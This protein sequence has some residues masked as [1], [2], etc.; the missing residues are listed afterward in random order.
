MMR[1][2]RSAILLALALSAVPAAA[3]QALPIELK[4]EQAL[5]SH[6]PGAGRLQ[7]GVSFANRSGYSFRRL[8]IECTAFAGGEP[9]GIG[10]GFLQNVWDGATVYGTVRI[11]TRAPAPLEAECRVANYQRS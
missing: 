7:V 2:G 6:Q 10:T 9:V 8:T 4:I 3:D 5:T 1:S 11:R